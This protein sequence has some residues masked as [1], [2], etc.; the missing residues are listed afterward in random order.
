MLSLKQLIQKQSEIQ[1][2]IETEKPH[3]KLPSTPI[4][5]V[6]SD[7]CIRLEGTLPSP[8]QLTSW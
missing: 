6:L 5:P 4:K 3:M 7:K 1:K 2:F 8:G